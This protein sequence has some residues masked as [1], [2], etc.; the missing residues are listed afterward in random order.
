MEKADILEMTVKHL[1]N[2]QL[3]L[4]SKGLSL[5]SPEHQPA[6]KNRY[7]TGFKECTQEVTRYLN[8]VPTIQHQVKEHLGEH[9]NSCVKNIECPPSPEQL[10]K[11]DMYNNTKQLTVQ[12]HVMSGIQLGLPVMS[13]NQ[14]VM[15]ATTGPISPGHH[16]Q[17]FV[18]VIISPNSNVSI[19]SSE[20]TPHTPQHPHTQ[21]SP[22]PGSV[23][24]LYSNTTSVI[25]QNA[26]LCKFPNHVAKE[27]N[28]LHSSRHQHHHRS[29]SPSSSSSSSGCSSPTLQGFPLSPLRGEDVPKNLYAHYPEE[30]SHPHYPEDAST[31]VPAGSKALTFNT[32]IDNQTKIVNIDSQYHQHNYSPVKLV[33]SHQQRMSGKLTKTWTDYTQDLYKYGREIL[34]QSPNS[35]VWRPW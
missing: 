27:I 16:T 19:M 33:Q 28:T 17:G 31:F 8:S 26:L 32:M 24:P 14:Q 12:G 4:S 13:N 5:I 10:I 23:I 34:V 20:N 30:A 29:P 15:L 22:L 3:R 25:Q 18:P 2:L 1:K 11:S 21:T 7:K 6:T 9:L 35:S